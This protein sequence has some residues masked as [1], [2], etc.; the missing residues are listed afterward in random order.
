MNNSFGTYINHLVIMYFVLSQLVAPTE[1][2]MG[3]DTSVSWRYVC[4]GTSTHHHQKSST[5]FVFSRQIWILVAMSLSWRI[6]T[7]LTGT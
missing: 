6:A 4:V 1:F 7:P 5:N 3:K 2:F